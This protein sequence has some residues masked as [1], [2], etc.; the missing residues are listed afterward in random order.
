MT[1]LA[2]ELLDFLMNLF[3]DQEAASAFIS[4]PEAVLAEAGWVV[5]GGHVV[6]AGDGASGEPVA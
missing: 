3:N 2:S 1:T 5:S 4:D 6:R